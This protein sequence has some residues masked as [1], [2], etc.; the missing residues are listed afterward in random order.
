MSGPTTVSGASGSPTFRRPAAACSPATTWSYTPRCAITRVG[1]VQICPQWKAHTLAMVPMAVFRSASS[2]TIPA[3]LPPSSSSS[4]FMS[5]PATSPMARPTGVEPVKLTMSTSGEAT[6]ACPASGDEPVTTLTTP[7]GKPA[8]WSTSPNTV[9]ARGS[10]GAGFT[11]TVLPMARAG[12]ILPA[13]FTMGKLYGV[14]QATTPTGCRSTMAPIRP[15]DA[16]AVE[17]MTLGG[18]GMVVGSMAP[19]A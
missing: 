14:M 16:S 17:G 10:C 13:M 12:P 18:S 4:R 19:R 5:R 9:T 3:P 6:S 8:S 11:T 1:A 2:N 7:A 15:P